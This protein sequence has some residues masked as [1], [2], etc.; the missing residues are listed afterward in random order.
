MSTANTPPAIT[1]LNGT[2]HFTTCY[3]LNRACRC[4]CGWHRENVAPE[5]HDEL[6][7]AHLAASIP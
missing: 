6:I 5:I 3:P 1:D 2:A 7:I 4:S